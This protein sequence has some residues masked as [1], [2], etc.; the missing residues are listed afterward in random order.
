ME[1]K[2]KCSYPQAGSWAVAHK[3]L[4]FILSQQFFASLVAFSFLILDLQ[5][6]CF[7]LIRKKD[8][9]LV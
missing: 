2:K 5:S 3:I 7:S 4:N 9:A 6:F 1:Y 8:F